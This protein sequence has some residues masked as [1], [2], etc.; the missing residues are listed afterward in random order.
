[1]VGVTSSILVPPT[2][3]SFGFSGMSFKKT[4]AGLFFLAA[5]QSMDGYRNNPIFRNA[6]PSA[7]WLPSFGQP[8]TFAT[9]L[10]WLKK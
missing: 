10:P 5:S 4:L 7:A 3:F 9:S 8:A 1:M 2:T 6:T